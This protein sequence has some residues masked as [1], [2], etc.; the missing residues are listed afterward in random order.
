MEQRELWDRAPKAGA[1]P[2]LRCPVFGQ[3]PLIWF[4]CTACRLGA[5]RE[6]TV[7]DL[8]ATG[9]LGQVAMQDEILIVLGTETPEDSLRTAEEDHR[10]SGSSPC[11]HEFATV[12]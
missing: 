3:L 8:L 11:A 4:E 6:S 12:N 2:E 5:R 10:L 1:L 7:N 9:A